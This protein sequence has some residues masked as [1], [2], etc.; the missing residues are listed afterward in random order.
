MGTLSLCYSLAGEV[1]IVIVINTVL[2]IVEDRSDGGNLKFPL[3]SV[4]HHLPKLRGQ[5]GDTPADGDT[6]RRRRLAD[7]DASYYPAGLVRKP[8]ARRAAAVVVLVTERFLGRIGGPRC[9]GQV[10]ADTNLLI[11]LEL[12]TNHYLQTPLV[13]RLLEQRIPSRL[14]LGGPAE[15]QHV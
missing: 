15:A 5:D 7:G 3:L 8:R 13:D 6:D 12:C 10:S 14:I 4:H 11:K 1:L 9:K 2:S